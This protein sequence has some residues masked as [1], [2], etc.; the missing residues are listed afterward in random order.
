MRNYIKEALTRKIP[1]RSPRNRRITEI[2]VEPS[3][4]L[5]YGVYFSIA[6]LICLTVLEAVHVVVLRSFSSEIFAAISLV[7][8]AILGAF[9]GQKG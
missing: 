7:I 3:N 6:A 9:F 2:E 8:G 5:V 1:V 4:R